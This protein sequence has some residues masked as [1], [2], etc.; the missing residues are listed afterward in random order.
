VE[1]HK[2]LLYRKITEL[3]IVK[4]DSVSSKCCILRGS[5]KTVLLL[6]LVFKLIHCFFIVHLCITSLISLF[7][8]PSCFAFS[9]QLLFHQLLPHSL[10]IPLSFFQILYFLMLF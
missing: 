4:E 2:T 10:S 8:L 3:L 9:E 6:L 5:L 7:L 1:Q